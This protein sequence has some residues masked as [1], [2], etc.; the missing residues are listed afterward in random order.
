MRPTKVFLAVVDFLRTDTLFVPRCVSPDLCLLLMADLGISTRGCPVLATH[1]YTHVH[2]FEGSFRWD[3]NVQCVQEDAVQKQSLA[4]Q[5]GS[6]PTCSHSNRD[7]H[8][9]QSS[10]RPLQKQDSN[11]PPAY[12]IVSPQTSSMLRCSN[13][14]S[15]HIA[16][17]IAKHAAQGHHRVRIII[18]PPN[19]HSSSIVSSTDLGHESF[20]VVFINLNTANAKMS[21]DSNL[22]PEIDLLIQ[23]SVQKL[24]ENIVVSSTSVAACSVE[25]M[26]ATVRTEN[27]F[28]LF[29]SVS[30]QTVQ[31]T[32]R[33]V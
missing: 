18:M 30:L 4:I 19:T 2:L 1:D 6:H 12:S 10:S 13:L 5:S 24:L 15:N 8:R 28:G 20:P 31:I 3:S 7:S 22:M 25:A 16:P 33:M 21:I 32:I 23:S 27:S 9:D 11:Q 14:V 26:L 29:E 17:L